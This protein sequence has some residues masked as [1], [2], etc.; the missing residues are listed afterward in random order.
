MSQETNSGDY[1]NDL[2]VKKETGWDIGFP[3]PAIRE[4]AD[5]LKHK[6]IS[7]LI[8]GCGN[9]YEAQYL[10]ESGFTN[11]T[12]IDIA[13]ALTAALE[14][15]FSNESGK[16]IKII[17]GDFF[18]HRGNY[19]LILEQ[20]FLSALHPSLRTSYAAQMRN[21]LHD[22]GHLAGVLFSRHFDVN[23]P[24]GGT[25]EEYRELFT[26]NFIIKTME[27]CYNSIDRRMGNEVFINLIAK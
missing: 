25:V 27:P 26:S 7:I 24:Y 3:S 10:L 23:P 2:Y 14:K 13:P 22:G 20:T 9:S 5:Q 12:L 1:W 18:E 11:I 4:Y 16:R 17:T 19:D 8:P 6:D 15:K 21:L